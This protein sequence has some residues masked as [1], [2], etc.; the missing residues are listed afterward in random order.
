[1]KI[2]VEQSSIL[3]VLSHIQSIVERKNTIPILS[4]VMIK[5]ENNKLLLTATDMDIEIIESIDAEVIES[6]ATTVPAHTLYDIVRKLQDGSQVTIE[7]SDDINVLISSGKSNFNLGSLPSDDFPVMSNEESEFNFSI[8]VSDFTK[9]IDKTKFAIS[10]EETR[11]YLNGVFFHE[12]EGNLVAVS[13]DGHRLAKVE[14]EAPQG[15]AGMPGVII[16]RKTI[17]EIRKLVD[18]FDGALNINLSENKIIFTIDSIKFT[19]KLID[20]TFPDYER[21]I[22]KGNDKVLTLNPKEFSTTV[23]RVST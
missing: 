16:P 2:I 17:L 7:Q 14:I 19:S 13:T 10:T 11:Y 8:S 18:S 9:I 4:N 1:M 20:G 6:G 15:S 5:A 22:P 23:D 21:V 12:K 3:R